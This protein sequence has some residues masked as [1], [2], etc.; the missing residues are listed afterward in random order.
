M[1]SFLSVRFL[2]F[3]IF[4]LYACIYKPFFDFLS[5]QVNSSFGSSVGRRSLVSYVPWIFRLSS[6]WGS[7]FKLK[8]AYKM[9]TVT[10][11]YWFVYL[12]SLEFDLTG[13]AAESLLGVT[14]LIS[15]GMTSLST[16]LY[17]NKEDREEARYESSFG[18]DKMLRG[19]SKTRHSHNLMTRDW[20]LCR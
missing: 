3:E 14:K 5:F 1:K 11:S 15:C 20:R 16:L 13:G 7:K 8:L 17:A 2:M 6:L 4:I 10:L 12:H 18:F 19:S 9:Y